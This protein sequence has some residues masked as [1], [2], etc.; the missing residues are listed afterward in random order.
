MRYSFAFA[1]V[2]AGFVMQSV[3]SRQVYHRVNTS[4][5]NENF[6]LD[7]VATDET[8]SLQSAGELE[9]WIEARFRHGW[10]LPNAAT[11]SE[12]NKQ[13]HGDGIFT[14][15]GQIQAAKASS[16]EE[17]L[18]S[19][20]P[21][22]NNVFSTMRIGLLGSLTGWRA[23]VA[24]NIIIVFVVWLVNLIFLIYSVARFSIHDGLGILY[25]GNCGKVRRLTLTAHLFINLLSTIMLSAS[26]YTMQVLAAPTRRE[27]DV[28]HARRKWLD[29][30]IQSVGNFVHIDPRRTALWFL[31]AAS[32][33]PLHLV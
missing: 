20:K 15:D 22:S 28:V 2:H 31:L 7:R 18:R 16:Y 27:V 32:S 21:N 4:A 26:N 30:G 9:A 6:E 24:I 23:T 10:I 19:A 25:T 33:V 3:S 14:Q 29:V 5:E 8:P 17:T 13:L 12:L 11:T 1:T